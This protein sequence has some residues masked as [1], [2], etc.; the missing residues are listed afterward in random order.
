M[1]ILL[2]GD[3]VVIHSVHIKGVDSLSLS[4]YVEAGDHLIG[5][6]TDAGHTVDYLRAHQVSEGFPDSMEAL[7]EYGVVI[8]SDIGVNSLTL[9]RALFDE[10]RPVPDRRSII[11]DWVRGGG[12]LLMVGGYLSFSGFEGKAQ[13]GGTAVED[14]LP[15]T[16]VPGDDRV[17]MPAGARPHVED[18]DHGVLDGVDGDWPALL[19]Y[20]RVVA[21]PQ[22]EVPVTVGAGDPLLALWGVGDGRAAVFT[23]DCAPHWA[24]ESF[25][26]WPGYARLFTNLITRLGGGAN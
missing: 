20:N 2:A 19:G 9:S 22:A 5:V 17:E 24:P 8:L 3:S 25:L 6:L 1:K 15:V 21:K 4:T 26:A 12:G 18:A 23:S 7:A 14:V 13:Y 10:C 11:A 16:C